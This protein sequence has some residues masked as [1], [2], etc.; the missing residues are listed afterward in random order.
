[1]TFQK[2]KRYASIKKSSRKRLLKKNF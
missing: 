2:K 1:M